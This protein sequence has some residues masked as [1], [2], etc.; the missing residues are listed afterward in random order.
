[1]LLWR[2]GHAAKSEIFGGCIDFVC[3]SV[4]GDV[5]RMMGGSVGGV[6]LECVCVCVGG[7]ADGGS[8]LNNNG[9]S[10]ILE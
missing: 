4:R 9:L 2:I 7:V 8:S 6:W 1:M 5:G 3:V 10:E